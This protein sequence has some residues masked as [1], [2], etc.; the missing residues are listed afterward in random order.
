[1]AK[2]K[3]EPDYALIPG[4]T[5]REVIEQK[6]LSQA[7]LSR[8]T[9]L[10]EKTVSQLLSGIAPITYEIAAKL[11]LALGIP[12]RFW[13]SREMMYRESLVR[14]EE[15]KH[16]ESA[17]EW[18]KLIPV[19]VLIERN[20]ISASAD[21]SML[22]RSV[23]K[24]FG[25]SSIEAWH[26]AWGNPCVQCR[27]GEAHDRHPGYVAAW[28]RIG[29]LQAEAVEARPYDAAKFREVLVRLRSLTNLDIGD[30]AKEV[31][32]Q[33]AEAG[34]VVIFTKEIDRAGISGATRWLTKDRA[35]IQLSLKYKSGDQLI[36]TFFHEA[37]HILLHGK[38]KVFMEFGHHR[39]TPE[40]QEA[41]K[42]A[43]D[44][45]I[46]PEHARRLPYL[47]TRFQIEEFA[48]LLEVAPE[49]VVGRL[50]H[51]GLVFNSAFRDLKRKV[52]WK[53]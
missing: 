48:K 15:A 51:D 50:Q 52:D 17:I 3:F 31:K 38:K 27:G 13:N 23:L 7:E 36:F 24:F 9:G 35:L 42:F 12:A 43:G 28:L 44:L 5:I 45:L 41:N 26:E 30:W 39:D 16:L 29:E 4:E 10:T 47:R 49:I 14:L 33:C 46:P 18:L 21:K 32:R 2:Y 22:V 40:E 53:T 34:V 37:G 25:V 11:E 20:L 8:R 1:M 6:S 19:P